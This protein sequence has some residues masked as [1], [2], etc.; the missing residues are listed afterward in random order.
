MSPYG[1]VT[2]YVRPPAMNNKNLNYIVLAIAALAA[3]LYALGPVLTPFAVALVLAYLCNPLVVRLARYLT[4]GG[5]ITLVFLLL[6][7]FMVIFAVVVAP[8]L[9]RQIEDLFMALPETLQTLKT[10][11]Q[12]LIRERLGVDINPLDIDTLIA[13]ARANWSSASGIATS[14]FDALT[15][16][17]K[18]IL[19]WLALLLLVP[20]L[21]FYFLRDWS[22]FWQR[23]AN[24]VPRR[25]EPKV[26]GIVREID[27]VLGAFLRGQLIVMSTLATLY[28]I[29]LTIIGLKYG[30]LIGVVAGF[31]N[32]IPYLGVGIGVLVAVITATFQFENIGPILAVIGVFGAGQL[33]DAVFLTPFLVGERIGLHPVA[34]IFAVLAGGQLFGLTGVLIALPCAAAAAV[35]FRHAHTR[36]RHSKLYR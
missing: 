13:T 33:L 34:V 31:L 2:H 12:P 4:R 20:V 30:I 35:L 10:H 23:A 27:D 25:F 14:L 11:W 29:G 16:S 19:T 6:S 17:G 36:Y 26:V 1:A 7:V 32:F 15:R 8:L 18:V 28:S 21:M 5:A 9:T 3:L 22:E 24:L